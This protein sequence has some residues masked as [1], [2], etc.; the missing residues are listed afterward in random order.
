MI[1]V[2]RSSLFVIL[3]WWSLGFAPVPAQSTPAVRAW[4]DATLMP[5]GLL[6]STMEFPVAPGTFVLLYPRWIPGTHAPGGP[7]ENLA[8]TAMGSPEGQSVSWR[9]DPLDPYRFL[10]EI[11][12]NLERLIVNLTYIANAATI[13]SEGADCYASSLTAVIAWNTCLLYPEGPAV[14]DIRVDLTLSLPPEWQCASSLTPLRREGDTVHFESTS[15]EILIDSPLI[16]GR[17]RRTWDI[18][19]EGGTPHFLH[20]VSES[21][22]ALKLDDGV[23]AKFKN[24]VAEAMALF[25]TAHDYP[26]HFLLVLSDSIPF[27]G[28]EHL[29]SSLNIVGE[30]G[31]REE[32]VLPTT[33]L[34]VA[35][36]Y[37]HRW[38]GK[39]HRPRG[40]VVPG[41]QEPLDTRLLWVYEGLGEYLGLVL[42]ARAGFLATRTQSTL[43][44]A[45]QHGWMGLGRTLIR[46]TYQKGRRSIPLEDTVAAG[47]LRR[48]E[49]RFWSA[50]NRPQDYYFEG[51][52]LWFEI[53]C[54]LREQSGGKL[55]LD[56]FNRRFL[57]RYEPEWEMM[58]YD[59]SGIVDLL[60]ELLPYNWSGLIESRVRGLQE[61]LP[62]DWL[63]RAGYR[64]SYVDQ[65]TP[66]E[67]FPFLASLGMEVTEQGMISRI[68]PGG[69][70][71]RAKLRESAQIIGVN[72]RKFSLPRLTDAVAG[73]VAGRPVELLLLRGGEFAATV[74]D[75]AGGL[76]YADLVRDESRPDR[77]ADI[78]APKARKTAPVL[79]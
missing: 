31:L 25:G 75:Y 56:D 68:I 41:F 43:E 2:D 79:N 53:D 16:A 34:L 78:F 30:T 12:E 64:L 29:R 48:G 33:G 46:L 49:S 36:E 24:L 40:M 8:E 32:E 45:L 73:T 72:G 60:T 63:E 26:Y 57:G 27:C 6:K 10:V 51:A 77:L 7:I 18:T 15:L 19:P 61:D 37:S 65:P 11:P 28:L 47:Y 76:R 23:S 44:G 13:N 1:H 71:D 20:V 3:G 66:Y 62:L 35:H 70:A 69:S 67:K 59:E 14:K 22:H 9:R 21:D 17:Y 58:G 38:C 55:S 54:L 52:L 5:R 50:L 39:Y 4:V 42:A 74:L